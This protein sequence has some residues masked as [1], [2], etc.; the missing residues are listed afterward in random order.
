MLRAADGAVLR[1]T[2]TDDLKEYLEGKATPETAWL[3]QIQQFEEAWFLGLRLVAGVSLS[4]LK[5]EFGAEALEPALSVV[6]NLVE[7]KLL[8]RDGDCVRLT[9]RGRLIS[10]DVFEQFLGLHAQV[11]SPA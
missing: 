3:D 11:G 9:D 8:I 7:D 5:A 10:N 1:S 2:V 4:A 6:E